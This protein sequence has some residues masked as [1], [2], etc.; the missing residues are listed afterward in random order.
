M[1]APSTDDEHLRLL[2]IFHYVAGGMWAVFGCVPL[3]HVAVGLFLVIAPE[4][5][6]GKPEDDTRE[7]FGWLF[8]VIGT[9]FFLAAQALAICT[10][11]SGRF[12][13]RKV[14]YT[15]CFVLACIEC[16]L[17]PVGTVLGVFT[18]IVLSRDSVKQL[19]DKDDRLLKAD[20]PSP[21]PG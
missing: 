16:L 3:I 14:R 1:N 7:V 9:A 17:L 5:V 10:I 6:R 2:S 11:F 19:F 20:A 12:L 15:Y 18:I 13:R 4:A 21:L 8:A